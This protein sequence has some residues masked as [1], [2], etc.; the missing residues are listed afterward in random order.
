MSCP[1]T[2]LP[3]PRAGSVSS[4]KRVRASALNQPNILTIHDIAEADGTLYIAKLV[5]GRT[6]RDL[7]VSGDTLP[8]R[9]LLDIAVQ[10]AEALSN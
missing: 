3:I 2:S 4:K 9:K 6:L 10:T 8:T 7:I 1:V 5:E